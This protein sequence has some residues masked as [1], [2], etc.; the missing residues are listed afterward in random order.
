MDDA[1]DGAGKDRRHDAAD[2]AIGERVR[3]ESVRSQAGKQDDVMGSRER[4]RPEQRCAEHRLQRGVR[5]EDERRAVRREQVCRVERR[6]SGLLH[7]LAHPPEVPE[8]H[9][10]VAGT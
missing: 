6:E 5:I 3:R 10:V 1:N 7:C 4:K 9:R 2:F 8:E